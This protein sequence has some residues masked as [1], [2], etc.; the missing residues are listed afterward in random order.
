MSDPRARLQ[1]LRFLISAAPGLTDKAD[2]LSRLDAVADL[3]KPQPPTD[4]SIAANPA[5][6]ARLRQD[7]EDAEH[8]RDAAKLKAMKVAM[9]NSAETAIAIIVLSFS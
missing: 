8:A 2:W 3:L 9:A 6:V 1:S 5:E 4:A 7:V